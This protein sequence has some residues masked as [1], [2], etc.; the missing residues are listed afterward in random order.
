MPGWWNGIIVIWQ[1]VW[2]LQRN[3]FFSVISEPVCSKTAPAVFVFNSVFDSSFETL[4][5]LNLC[6]EL[7]LWYLKGF[8]QLQ[9]FYESFNKTIMIK[10][11]CCSSNVYSCSGCKRVYKKHDINI[12]GAIKI[13]CRWTY[14]QN[15]TDCGRTASWRFS[16]DIFYTL[17]TTSSWASYCK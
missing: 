5:D 9:Y 8:I 2:V 13:S 7:L 10:D 15:K 14:E 17:L 1:I 16:G 12:P 3:C 4:W 11:N 6:F